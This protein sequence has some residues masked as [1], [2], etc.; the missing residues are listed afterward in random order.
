MTG[1]KP[2]R[3]KAWEAM[4]RGDYELA[5]DLYDKKSKRDPERDLRK[6]DAWFHLGR[7]EEARCALANAQRQREELQAPQ[8]YRTPLAV[9]TWLCG[10][11]TAATEILKTECDAILRGKTGYLTE[12]F[13]ADEGAYLFY[14]G[15]S[16][17]ND[18]A[19]KFACAY[20]EKISQKRFRMG[21][22]WPPRLHDYLRNRLSDTGMQKI[23]TRTRED[24]FQKVVVFHRTPEETERVHALLRS[25]DL[26]KL[27][28]W[29]AIKTHA[30]EGKRAARPFYQ[31]VADA[32]PTLLL[33]EEWYLARSELKSRSSFA[34]N[35]A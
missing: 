5:L 22:S 6:V 32:P 34:S 10:K 33:S 7:F 15:A 18:E 2:P 27:H 12:S 26:A 13:G 4:T 35:S 30:R 23:V 24:D 17:G 31:L 25:R 29:R 20:L 8:S 19:K 16:I 9:A 21:S 14:F 28:F 1:A 11:R 3:D